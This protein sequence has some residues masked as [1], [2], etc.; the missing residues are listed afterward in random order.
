VR[1]HEIHALVEGHHRHPELA[2]ELHVRRTESGSTHGRM[3]R[4]VAVIAK[5]WL[6]QCYSVRCEAR[7]SHV[8]GVKAT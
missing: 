4:M 2:A 7:S 1:R 5:M 3:T 6:W 8:G